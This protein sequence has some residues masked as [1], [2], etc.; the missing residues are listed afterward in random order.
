MINQKIVVYSLSVVLVSI[1]VVYCLVAA[2]E[3]QDF[4]ELTDMGIEG[5]TA[6]KQFEMTF[7]TATGI[8]NFGLG[9]WVLRSRRR[10][11]LPYLVS[12]VVSAGLIVIYVASRTV[13]VPIVGVEYYIGRLDMISKILQVIAI[14][15]SGFAIYG[16]QKLRIVKKISR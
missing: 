11:V 10:Q 3:Y 1:G 12:G 5:E 16:V 15:L 13:G 8:I 6:E 4:K 14:A 2:S 9:I 7:F